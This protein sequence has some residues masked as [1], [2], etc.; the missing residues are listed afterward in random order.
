MSY[1]AIAR[2]WRPTTFEEIAGQGHVTRT[3]QNALRLK[4]IHHA[5]LF[6][7]AR[8]VGKTTAARTMARCLNCKQGPTPTPCGECT[9]CVEVLGGRSPDVVE[10]DGASNN[11]VNDVRELRDTVHYPPQSGSYRVYIIDEVH[12]LST[13][14]FNALLKT[15]E[16]P[17]P[18]V[19]FIFA[20]TEPQKIPDTVLSRVQRFDFKR[21]PAKVVVERLR[22]I[23]ES[24]GLSISDEGLR[25]IARAGEGSMRD[26][27]S[28]LDQVIAFSGESVSDQEVGEILGLVDRGLLHGMLG[29]LIEGDPARCLDAIA[30]VHD[31]G[32]EMSQFTE[33][34]LELLRNAALVVL[35]P[36]ARKHLD[37]PEEEIT[38]LAALCEGV[39]VDVFSRWFDA[40]LE[41][42]DQVSRSTRPRLVLE[43]AVARLAGVRPVQP[44]DKLLERLE[45]LEKKLRSGGPR[46]GGGGGGPRPSGR[47]SAPRV[48]P[49][50]DQRTQSTQSTQSTHAAPPNAPRGQALAFSAPAPRPEAVSQPEP[51]PVVQAEPIAEPPHAA[52][53][54]FAEAPSRPEPAV[55]APA[56]APPEPSAAA[57]PEPVAA[58]PAQVDPEPA[59]AQPAPVEA[60]PVEPEPLAAPPE[61]VAAQPE[62]LPAEPAPPALALHTDNEAR[63]ASFLDELKGDPTIRMV[64]EDSVFSGIRDGVLTVGFPTDFRLD[65]CRQLMSHPKVIAAARQVFDVTALEA[66]PREDEHRRTR[67]ERRAARLKEHE[68][69]L[70]VHARADAGITLLLDELGGELTALEP[71]S[72]PEDLP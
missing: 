3:L 10:I 24:E 27:Q 47:F 61:P 44:I 71:L 14:A 26:S 39:P 49:R 40:L 48:S 9:S 38:Q 16:E 2:K 52:A 21:I 68:E 5:L 30:T 15:L 58:Q 66:L 1:Q 35:S 53:P 33:E 17:P 32:Y 64:V 60:R 50:P 20:T 29:G 41:V 45:Q 11:S 23:S 4:R 42:H 65:H 67:T 46:G 6:T 25:L 59:A 8:G 51:T 69:E 56:P 34:L 13:G 55:A 22:R 7:G 43:M 28:L 19:V 70:W 36:E 54:L 12:M 62:P 57:H 63:Y 18:H 72:L 31:Y 37:A